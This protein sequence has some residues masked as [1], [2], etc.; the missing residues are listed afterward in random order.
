MADEKKIVKEKLPFAQEGMIR[1]LHATLKRYQNIKDPMTRT[2][3]ILDK[4]VLLCDTLQGMMA[5]NWT[6]AYD[7]E[8][9][10]ASIITE[11]PEMIK[12][13]SLQTMDYVQQPMYDPHHPYG[14]QIEKAAQADFAS[15]ENP[16]V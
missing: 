5:C 12:N 11:I 6:G 15:K 10:T 14:Q 9:G 16:A 2:T 8:P 13:L 1:A 7:L 3:L 4:F